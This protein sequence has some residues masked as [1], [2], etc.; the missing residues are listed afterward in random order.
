MDESF[1]RAMCLE[2]IAPVKLLMRDIRN[3]VFII[4]VLLTKF[5]PMENKVI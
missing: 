1:Y 5:Y 3:Q 4:E 2:A